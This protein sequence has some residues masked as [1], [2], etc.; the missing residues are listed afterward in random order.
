MT[1]SLLTLERRVATGLALI[2]LVSGLA[3]L[4]WPERMLQPLLA[5][6]PPGLAL[7]Q[8]L[9][10]QPLAPLT[11]AQAACSGLLLAI[12]GG[13]LL[14]ALLGR[15]GPA[16][17]RLVLLWVVVEKLAWSALLLVGWQQQLYGN[18]SLALAAFDGGAAA[19]LWDLRR[20]LPAA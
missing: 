15:N 9:L 4:L 20:R 8:S 12:L 7:L 14:Q 18:A 11:L 10:S 17:L 6:P 3:Q 13:L 19:L 2:M 5:E 1:T 16:A